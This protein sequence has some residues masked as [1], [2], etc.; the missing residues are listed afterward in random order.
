VI[1][2]RRI[3]ILSLGT[4]Y[5]VGSP[6]AST[7]ANEMRGFVYLTKANQESYDYPIGFHHP[8]HPQPNGVALRYPHEAWAFTA[9]TLSQGKLW[10]S[11]LTHLKR[12]V[13]NP[14]LVPIPASCTT[15]SNI[16]GR[17]A[18]RGIAEAIAAQGI[19]RVAL[20]VVNKVAGEPTRG[21]HPPPSE[22]LENLSWYDD[23]FDPSSETVVYV[24]DVLTWGSHIAAVDHFIGRPRGALGI[25]V[26]C[27]DG[28]TRASAIK[29]RI[30][31]LTFRENIDEKQIVD[32]AEDG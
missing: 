11:A 8:N 18:A 6:A 3:P 22:L 4:Y 29:A 7:D 1:F 12:Q 28:A 14:V 17:W 31:T 30:R 24:D 25:T 26:A 10:Q 2:P 5:K 13:P 9:A 20:A 21:K 19:G 23:R 32:T 16:E 27:T 15:A